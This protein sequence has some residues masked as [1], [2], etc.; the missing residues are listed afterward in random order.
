MNIRELHN[1]N[2]LILIF[3]IST[4]ILLIT[5]SDN[6]CPFEDLE[7]LLQYYA[8]G[9]N[10]SNSKDIYKRQYIHCV[11]GYNNSLYLI[12][13]SKDKYFN[14]NAGIFIGSSI[15]IAKLENETINSLT[16][17]NEAEKDI[18]RN[19]SHYIDKYAVDYFEKIEN[20]TI[21]S[22]EKV[23]SINKKVYE[24]YEKK[25]KDV[26][27][28]K[29][30]YNKK[31]SVHGFSFDLNLLTVFVKYYGMDYYTNE[32]RSFVAGKK[33]T[34]NYMLLSYYFLNMKNDNINQKKLWSRIVLSSN[35]NYYK[36]KKYIG[37]Y[38]D[39]SLDEKNEKN[40]KDF[41]SEFLRQ[42]KK[43]HGINYYYFRL[44]NITDILD[45]GPKEQSDFAEEISKYNYTSNYQEIENITEGISK[46]IKVFNTPI[47]DINNY[48]QKHLIIFVNN[49]SNVNGAINTNTFTD[50]GI[51]VI[52]LVK[53]TDEKKD[54][55][56]IKDKF[57]DTFNVITFHEYDQL[58]DYIYILKSAIIYNVQNFYYT[59]EIQLK[60]INTDTSSESDPDDTYRKNI[61]YNLKITFDNNLLSNGMEK[62]YNYFHIQLTYDKPNTNINMT[63][64][65]SQGN[66][67]PDITN[68]DIPNFCL[69]SSVSKDNNPYINY[70]L[71]KYNTTN[72]FYISILANDLSY[73][74]QI[75]LKNTSS[76]IDDSNGRFGN[77]I[78]T[79]I[80]EQLIATYS[81]N[82]I[83]QKCPVDYFS[84]FKYFTS[85]VHHA[86]NDNIFYKIIDLDMIACLYKNVLGPYFDIL[87]DGSETKI[88]TDSGPYIGYA[89][90]LS[91]EESVDL[92]RNDVP[93]Y[94]INKLHP[95]LINSI[96]KS[97]SKTI[98]DNYNL[99]LTSEESDILKINHFTNML[100]YLE[101][102]Y[103]QATENYSKETKETKKLSETLKLAVFLRVLEH[104]KRED[105]DIE[106]E[107]G[108]LYEEKYDNYLEELSKTPFSFVTTNNTLNFQKM[109]VQSEKY[110]KITR[111]KK[112]LVSIVIA[113]ALLWSN[114]FN[115]LLDNLGDFRISL[116]LYDF[117]TNSTILLLDFEEDINKIKKEIDDIKEYDGFQRPEIVDINIILKQQKTLF[118]YYDKGIKKCIV[119]VSTN[120]AV[121]YRNSFTSPNID[122]LEDLYDEGIIVFDYSDQI[123]FI[124]EDAK[125]KNSF[126]NSTRCPF[127]QYVPFYDYPS[128]A[129]DHETLTK[130]I[131][132]FPIPITNI[133]N[134]NLDL[135]LGEDIH[136][137]FNFTKEIKKL[138]QKDYF[139]QYNILYFTF[140]TPELKVFFS[141]DYIY[142][143][144]YSYEESYS[145]DQSGKQ[146][147]YDLKQL[148]H[149]DNPL[150]YMTISSPNKVNNSIIYMDICD[151]DGNCLI[152]RFKLNFYI[153]FIVI[154]IG[155]LGYGIYICFCE[156]NFKKESNIFER[157]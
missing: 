36:N 18:L 39:T 131:S 110:S 96:I 97:E 157:K 22:P 62:N 107:I 89:L 130:T 1:L 77:A 31:Y 35:R 47:V 63:F 12:R 81:K 102:R 93:L 128:M 69:N 156:T 88:K 43:K 124:E 53:I 105:K 150:F 54:S 42:F 59:N 148:R 133:I 85:G 56:L 78:V 30:Y 9:I 34:I 99:Y 44:G 143:N 95:F 87:K 142:P 6:L 84:L 135:E 11:N 26:F 38:Y 76:D 121:V 46:F 29:E 112:C 20:K 3:I 144:N 27:D 73:S 4:N 94:L 127:I 55:N 71:K 139:D 151:N 50:N 68:Y 33:N 28:L 98:V 117:Q 2:F 119:I 91:I 37:I 66:S 108:Y 123:T 126:Y 104:Q 116:T 61:Y 45:N 145:I 129:D 115:K 113:E 136:Y 137:E 48:Y 146:I 24:I 19:L 92:Y 23:K 111:P 122:L 153:S 13:D 60:T 147:K 15:N 125:N 64:L 8:K 109:L 118:Q 25:M 32:V 140:D 67:F 82:L 106:K 83:Y 5:S 141:Q 100:E 101:E 155:I 51:Q 138:K 103:S 49:I 79:P 154:G 17:L 86:E 120:N 149:P 90:D 40:F 152:G 7:N 70:S 16:E 74:L 10:P 52:L 75:T 21:F 41:F 114:A 65:V 14:E 58:E 80:E 57:N 72:H 134:I 132:R